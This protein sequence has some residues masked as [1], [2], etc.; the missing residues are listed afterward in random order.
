MTWPCEWALTHPTPG[1]ISPP[2]TADGRPLPDAL[3]LAAATASDLERRSCV[4][5]D[6]SLVSPRDLTIS[7]AAIRRSFDAGWYFGEMDSGERG[8]VSDFMT[9]WFG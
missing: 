9:G 3:A 2:N 8:N 7:W 6:G 4:R 1:W 5:A